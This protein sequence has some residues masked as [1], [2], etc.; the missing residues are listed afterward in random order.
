MN[1]I[2][3][4]RYLSLGRRVLKPDSS[5]KWTGKLHCLSSTKNLVFRQSCR[6]QKTP[7][8]FGRRSN[9]WHPS[10]WS[11]RFDARRQSAATIQ[12]V[13]LLRWRFLVILLRLL[14]SV[15]DINP[16]HYDA[17]FLSHNPKVEFTVEGGACQYFSDIFVIFH[18]KL[19]M[20][21]VNFA[22][23]IGH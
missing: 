23:Q 11:S 14:N 19:N 21:T 13:S 18:D 12:G 1:R 2:L 5:Q 4:H 16:D 9:S 3:S 15:L 6:I 17:F 8:R 20:K 22:T 10:R 7:K